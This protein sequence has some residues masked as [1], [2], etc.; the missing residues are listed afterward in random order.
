MP[1]AAP[2]VVVENDNP[3]TL[4]FIV[5]STGTQAAQGV[6]L[7]IAVPASLAVTAIS[8]AGIC[9]AGASGLDCDLG[10]ISAAQER[11][12]DVTFLP[13]VLGQFTLDAIV[14]AANNQNTRDNSQHHQVNVL[15]NA[16][17]SIAVELSAQTVFFGDPVHVTITVR[18]LKSRAVLR[19]CASGSTTVG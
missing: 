7:Q 8:P 9:V 1:L 18:S 16:D 4:P 3:V 19:M 13:S 10:S 14:S 12:V 6:R 11:R 15:P 5:R 2:P 17:A